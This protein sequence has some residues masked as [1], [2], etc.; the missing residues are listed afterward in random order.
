MAN[1][2]HNLYAA[3]I[4]AGDPEGEKKV[5]EKYEKERNSVKEPETMSDK[6]ERKQLVPY[7]VWREKGLCGFPLF[8]FR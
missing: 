7:S 2:Q 6:K 5:T 4:S 3:L 1:S 8:I